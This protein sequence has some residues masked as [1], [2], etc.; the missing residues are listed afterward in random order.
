MQTFSDRLIHWQMAHGRHHLPWQMT[1]DPYAIWLS[2]IMLQQ[3]RVV[4]VMPYYQRF[5]HHF[6]DIRTLAAATTDDVL[7]QW[8]GLGYYSR[9]RNLHKAAQIIV[10]DYQGIFPEDIELI[11]SLPGIGRS[12]AAAIAVFAYG[13]H[14]AILDGNVKRVLTRYCGIAGDPGRKP[15]VS[16]LWEQA[17][18]LLPGKQATTGDIRAYTQALMD[19]G[20]TVCTRTK[21]RCNDCPLRQECVAWRQNQVGEFPSRKPARLLPVRETAF[22]LLIQ[23]GEILLE[24]RPPTGIWGGLWCLPEIPVDTDVA[25]WCSHHLGITQTTLLPAMPVFTHTFTHFRLHIH[26]R[27]LRAVSMVNP[28]RENQQWITPDKALETG[29]PVPVRKLLVQQQRLSEHILP[30][31]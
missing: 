16:L 7:A 27:P 9:G 30:V 26:P 10:R 4:T 14:H 22:L 17:E 8:S 11:W 28:A 19:L 18:A 23:N 2:E 1:R 24:K 5:L 3:T 31:K 25:R 21:A 12:T 6:P 20:A 29:I 13:A 15:V